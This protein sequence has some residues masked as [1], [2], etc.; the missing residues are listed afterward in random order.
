MLGTEFC[1]YSS[2]INHMVR[3]YFI[4]KVR[5]GKGKHKLMSMAKD[6]FRLVIG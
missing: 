3:T 4:R 2:C 5:W 1:L 6:Y